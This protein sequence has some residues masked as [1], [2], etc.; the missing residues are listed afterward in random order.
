LIG[1]VMVLVGSF[2]PW[3]GASGAFGGSSTAWELPIGFL[4]SNT[5]KPSDVDLGWTALVVLPLFLPLLLRRPL[6]NQLSGAI[7]FVAL[8]VPAD[9]VFRAESN[10][11]YGPRVGVYLALAGGAVISA[12]ATFAPPGRR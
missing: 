9:I 3:I 7:G 1:A 12:A 6:P 2:L 5:P 10:D 8:V 4:T 11:G